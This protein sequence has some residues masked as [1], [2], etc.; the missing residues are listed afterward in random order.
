[1][2]NETNCLN[3]NDVALE[4]SEKTNFKYFIFHTYRAPSAGS[5]TIKFIEV[6]SKAK[7]T[8]QKVKIKAIVK[9]VVCMQTETNSMM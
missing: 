2:Q 3:F 7:N 9:V 6:A 1:M 4:I 5:K 8:G